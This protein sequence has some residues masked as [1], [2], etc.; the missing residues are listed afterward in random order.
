VHE[1]SR[2]PRP[3][4]KYMLLR[5]L[6]VG[7]MAEVYLA[8]Q[9][10]PAGFEKECV[11]K[12]ILPSLAA[13]GQFVQMFLDEARIAA[14]LAHPHIVQ[15]FDLGQLGPQDYF[16]CMEHVH[17]ADLQQIVEAQTARGGKVP[18]AIALRLVSNVAEGLD[19]AHRATDKSGAPLGIVHRDVTPS[20]VMV[21]F[22]GV[23]K[24]LD[25]GIAKAAAQGLKVGR[26]EVGVIKG[27]IPY[28]S[29]EQVQGETLD[30]R[31]DLFS[32]GSILYE[33]TVGHKPFDGTN[34]AEISIKVLHDEP[35]APELVIGHYP[36]PL[37]AIVRR[38]LAKRPQDRYPSARDFQVD[39]D[40]FLVAGGIR[41]TS[42]EVAAY[43]DDLL[44]GR[45]DRPVDELLP[46]GPVEATDPTVPMRMGTDRMNEHRDADSPDPMMGDL[47]VSGMTPVVDDV[48]RNLGGGGGGMKYVVVLL[49]VAVAVGFWYLRKQ[50]NA[51]HASPAVDPN[52]PVVADPAKPAEAVKPAEVPKPAAEAPKPAEVAKPVEA[53]KPTEL[54]APT[55]ATPK[56]A[57][58]VPKPVAKKAVKPAPRPVA[59]PKPEGPRTLPRLP[60][61][62]PTDDAQ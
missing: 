18:L 1:A 55:V 48:R 16:L 60:S 14:R 11:I 33:L 35:Q 62:P 23:A 47:S 52:K 4:G 5:Q 30:A 2:F 49:V 3:F 13:D 21:S 7:G 20:N 61:P 8:R 57:A 54:P 19:H 10:G 29:P 44:P 45:R 17:G 36:E 24:I 6:A 9:S 27:K 50:M 46:G 34:P 56:P 28:M 15:I 53:P 31:S 25:F 40:E 38:A 26:T 32:L 22:D 37:A 59:K 39:L 42:H 12:R 58:E 51:S 43:L 41:C